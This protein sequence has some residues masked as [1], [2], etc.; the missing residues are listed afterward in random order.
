MTSIGDNI[1]L[2]SSQFSH[3]STSFDNTIP[4]YRILNFTNNQ[5]ISH[6][7]TDLV[8]LTLLAGQ[9]FTKFTYQPVCA[10]SPMNPEIELGNL[11]QSIFSWPIDNSGEQFG[12]NSDFYSITSGGITEYSDL[13][14]SVQLDLLDGQQ[15]QVEYNILLSANGHQTP[16]IQSNQRPISFL[17]H[18]T[19]QNSD[20]SL[21]D[22]SSNI[23][24]ISSTEQVQIVQS[25]FS[26]QDICPNYT[27]PNG[28]IT[29]DYGVAS[30]T[31]NFIANQ[32]I[33]VRF[34]NLQAIS[35][36]QKIQFDIDN[37]TLNEIKNSSYQGDDR[38]ILHIPMS[39]EATSGSLNV[40]VNTTSYLHQIDSINTISRDRLLPGQT[41][42][43]NTSHVR[44]DPVIMSE[45]GYQ[46]DNVKLILSPNSKIQSSIIEIEASNLYSSKDV[47]VTKGSDLIE[48]E[49]AT[50]SVNCSAGFCQIQWSFTSTWQLDDIDDIYWM[51]VAK[52]SN[53]LETGPDLI[54]RQT[55]YNEIENDLEIIQ[56]EAF[57]NEN[58]LHDWT[59][60]DWPFH[61]QS[62]ESITVNGQVRFQGVSNNFILANE[63]EIE[64]RL[65]AVPPKNVSGG[66]DT[67][68]ESPV[69]WSDS[70]F[71]EAGAN[72]Y[73]STIINT[74][75]SDIVPSNTSLEI[76]V[77]IVRTGPIEQQSETSI[78]MTAV[79]QR[80]RIL[81][82]VQ[83]PEII[84]IDVLDPAGQVP[85]DGHIWISGQDI[86]LRATI[87]DVEGLS[88]WITIWSWSESKDDLN[89]DGVM[90][91]DEYISTTVSLNTG[92]KSAI[93]DLPIFSWLDV[94]GSKESG[95]LSIFIETEDLAGN[96][97]SGG[98]SFGE[99]H[100]LMT[101]LVQNQY[102]TFFDFDALDLDLINNQILP[103]HEH[104]LQFS[105]TDANGIESL[106][107]IQLAILGR[108]DQEKCFIHHEPR[109][110]VTDYDTSCF[111]ISPEV[112]I[113]QQEGFLVWD[114]EIRFR[115]SWNILESLPQQSWIPSIKIYDEG[116]DLYLGVSLLTMFEWSF[117]K[118]IEFSEFEI[119]E[120]SQPIGKISDN[121][122][123]LQSND[124]VEMN[125]FLQ[126]TNLSIQVEYLTNDFSVTGTIPNQQL[127][128]L[129]YSNISSQGL[130]N[131]E[132]IAKPSYL[133]SSNFSLE[134]TLLSPLSL[135]LATS[136]YI[137][138]LDDSPPMLSLSLQDLLK[139]DSNRL[140][141]IPIVATISDDLPL[142][143]ARLDVNWYFSENG[144]TIQGTAGNQTIYSTQATQFNTYFEGLL[145]ITP[146]D[147][148]LLS[149]DSEIIIWF[150]STDN[151]GL[152]LIGFGTLSDPL[153]PRFN[154][155]DF[156][157]KLD[158][159]SI[160]TDNPVFGQNIEII[161]KI[162]NVGQLGGTVEVELVDLE[163]QILDS[164][165]VTLEPGK[166]V[167]TSWS[168]EAWT[169]G[170]IT[171]FVN[172]T[173]YSQSKQVSIEDI[174]EF[175]SSN[176][177][178][179][180]LLG[181]IGLL[182]FLVVG[183]FG[184]AYHRRSKELE[185]YTKLHIENIV[186][187]RGSPP[188]R[189]LELDIS[190]Q[191]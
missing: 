191:E 71:V 152:E 130:I 53:G 96:L 84:A 19:S 136:T 58:A 119:F 151:S 27:F 52:D 183:G 90:D 83:S 144:S 59:D 11:N 114:V 159:I 76:S 163:G 126:F 57:D 180:G 160:E 166:L 24:I 91:L 148:S 146:S 138:Y 140:F 149:R 15:V 120:Q 122:I 177:E 158:T 55:A 66:E 81:F 75:N 101:L 173:N 132:F 137:I 190:E 125:L 102:T 77:H 161:T 50:T 133:E 8:Q 111:A 104:K 1:S 87:S 123:W 131:V 188:P 182:I 171:F 54:S 127:S 79:Y 5:E 128:I 13:D 110:S 18:M 105:L 22:F 73:F 72:G 7:L 185:Q 124:V 31:L 41:I 97:L 162:V 62:N 68:P 56:F 82:D 4:Q 113:T 174:E 21:N 95:R 164:K 60:A 85:A 134:L 135:Q 3:S 86:P 36:V 47:I 141:E 112:D 106:D 115:I 70:W 92:S 189:P 12:A 67:W 169:T 17:I 93:I 64:V 107:E 2:Y 45:H 181:L 142:N 65:Q 129:N 176:R 145:D 156:E 44:F 157:P 80:T 116:Q 33:S 153:K 170:D 63:A 89:G 38:E 100:D 39:V 16:G 94:R 29:A 6:S 121:K 43:I 143:D 32:N 118:D 168:F 69:N 154:W 117:N 186:R 184:F 20:S 40:N 155:I 34:S 165:L 23:S 61:I 103:G 30:C 48:L 108:D 28:L 98:G 25:R 74:P 10:E 9:K 35:P 167:E 139:V 172:L 46:F 187:K 99:D 150:S 78:D 88:P 49:E 51:V 37:S 42:S 109:F 179:N 14:G 147:E 175:N 26:S 178:L